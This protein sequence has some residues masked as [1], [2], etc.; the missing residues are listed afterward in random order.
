MDEITLKE[1]SRCGQFLPLTC[2]AKR[3]CS[4]DGYS[5]TCKSCVKAV[6]KKNHEDKPKPKWKPYGWLGEYLGY[7]K[8]AECIIVTDKKGKKK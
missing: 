7:S 4:K 8:L 2:F 5:G 1:C 3:K 6:R